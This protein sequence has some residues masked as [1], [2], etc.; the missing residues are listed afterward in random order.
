MK[1]GVIG[2]GIIG[3][4]VAASIVKFHRTAQVTLIDDGRPYKTS[5]AGQGY[6]WSIHRYDDK[7]GFQ[8][9]L[10]AK[11]AWKEL[12]GDDELLE[13]KGSLLIS[14][15]GENELKQYFE[16]AKLGI[17]ELEFVDDAATMN[18]ALK[19]DEFYGVYFPDDYT[20]TPPAL[21]DFLKERYDLKL[22]KRTVLCLEDE[23]QQSKVDYLI[24]CAGPWIN[25]L[26]DVGVQPVRG[27]LLEVN[28]GKDIDMDS[29]NNDVPI[30]EYGYGGSGVHFTL[31]F[32]GKYL[33]GASREFVGFSTDNL[34]QIE[35]SILEHAK[36]FLKDDAL[37]QTC[38]RRIGYRPFCMDQRNFN[39]KYF[40]TQLETDKRII[41]VY[42]FEGQGVLYAPLAG[43]DVLDLLK[44]IDIID[45]NASSK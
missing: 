6:L 41:L 8:T 1:V 7:I 5:Q 23:L 31:S 36:G 20:C 15:K 12:L 17:K 22:D 42:G 21:I 27:V 34:D 40:V 28:N 39:R 10:L 16:R 19:S 45:E 18:Q 32:R 33:V 37:A 2:D 9:S 43:L 44:D 26:K 11:D 35:D 25:E 3:T 30:M 29:F 38:N 14:P 24:V 13:R 4:A